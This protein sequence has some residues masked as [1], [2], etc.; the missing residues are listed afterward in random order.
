MK[1]KRSQMLSIALLSAATGLASAGTV[2]SDGQDLVIKSKGD[3]GVETADGKNSF[4]IGGRIQVDYNSYDG[5]I[6][7]GAE[8]ETG[9]DLFFRRARLALKG[10]IDGVWKYK[11]QFN[12]NEADGGDVEDLYIAYTGLGSLAQLT[13]GQQKEPFGL[14]ELTSSKYI[15][16]IERSMPTNAYAPGRNVGLKLNGHQGMMTY[17]VGAFRQGNGPDNEMDLALTGRVTAAPIASGSNVVHLGAGFSQRDGE[18]ND[19]NARLGVRGGAGKTANK[20]AASYISGD[21]DEQ[22]VW[23]IEGAVVSGP[24]HVQAEYFDSSLSGRNGAPDLDS[25]GYYAQAGWF[26]TGESRPYD[27]GD[28]AFGKV[29]P[30]SSGGAWELFA[31]YDNMDAD[32]AAGISLP[33]GESANTMT[34][35]AN[36]YANKNVRVGIN[37]VRAD[38]DQ[39]INGEDSGNALVARTQLI[40]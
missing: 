22:Q 39:A 37:Y 18:F 3:L 12:V 30:S 14:E 25:S 9:S 31:R 38:T 40:W 5:V 1:L 29:A 36:W 32:S 6:N 17:A 34:L 7:K 21:A 4:A 20:Y 10:K 19:I 8:G 28:G 23:N 2:T 11:M 15:T 35:G 16:A 26:L 24:V 13:L 27:T 33:T